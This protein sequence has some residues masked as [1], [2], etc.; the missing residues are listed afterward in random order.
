MQTQGQ[1]YAPALVEAGGWHT[2]EVLQGSVVE[3]HLL[4]TVDHTVDEVEVHV[5]TLGLLAILGI[6]LGSSLGGGRG[7]QYMFWVRGLWRQ[8]E[9]VCQSWIHFYGL[10]QGAEALMLSMAS[11]LAAACR[12]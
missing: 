4:L 10:R 5:H 3:L 6:S 8:A 11:D 12:G 2:E 9:W 7:R 1:Q